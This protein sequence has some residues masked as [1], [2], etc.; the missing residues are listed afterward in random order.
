VDHRSGAPETSSASLVNVVKEAFDI[1]IQYPIHLSITDG[2]RQCIKSLMSLA[3]NNVPD[4]V[5][6]LPERE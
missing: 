4:F 2:N 3:K 1:G 6:S 5:P